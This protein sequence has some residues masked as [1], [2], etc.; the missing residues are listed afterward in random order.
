M[1][2]FP[3][4]C[5]GKSSC[6]TVIWA[7]LLYCIAHVSA[8]ARARSRRSPVEWRPRAQSQPNLCRGGRPRWAPASDIP[9]VR[10][11]QWD[12]SSYSQGTLEYGCYLLPVCTNWVRRRFNLDWEY[13]DLVVP[14]PSNLCQLRNFKMFLKSVINCSMLQHYLRLQCKVWVIVSLCWCVRCMTGNDGGDVGIDIIGNTPLSSPLHNHIVLQ[15]Y[16]LWERHGILFKAQTW[17]SLTMHILKI[18]SF[19]MTCPWSNRL[20]MP[21]GR[22]FLSIIYWLN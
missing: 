3:C 5:S 22:S 2:L 8:E 1:Y 4:I 13:A 15:N 9:H 6:H 7:I 14:W 10:Y 12:Y 19:V 20:C 17:N 21:Q 18:A 11:F 16:F